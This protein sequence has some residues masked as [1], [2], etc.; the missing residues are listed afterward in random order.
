MNNPVRAD[1]PRSAGAPLVAAAP[2]LRA[3]RLAFSRS[4]ARTRPSQPHLFPWFP[5]VLLAFLGVLIWAIV[6]RR[7]GAGV[8]S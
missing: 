7:S 4:D 5:G 3:V 8:Q 6:R 1:H 2:A